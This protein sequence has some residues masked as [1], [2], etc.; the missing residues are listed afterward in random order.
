[1]TTYPQL[2]DAFAALKVCCLAK[3]YIG[4]SVHDMQE[5]DKRGEY[6]ILICSDSPL[7]AKCTSSNEAGNRSAPSIFSP[8]PLL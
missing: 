5:W 4:E 7:V 1:M 2:S 6:F 8:L 3:N